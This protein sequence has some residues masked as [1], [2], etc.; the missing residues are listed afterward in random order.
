[1]KRFFSFLI[2]FC[3]TLSGL[4][5]LAAPQYDAK[6]VLLMDSA[7]GAVLYE[8]NAHEPLPPASVTKV[9]TML[10]LMEAIDR[11]EVGYDTVVTASERARSMGGST[12][13]LDTGEQMTIDDLLKGIAVASGNDACVAVAEHLCGS[14]EAFV[15]RMNLRASELGMTNTHFVN[16]N[17]L[18]ADGHVSSAMDIAIMSRELMKHTDIFKYTT[19]WMDSLRDG[20][21]QLANTN[22]LIRFYDGATGLKTG[23]TNNAL[24]CLSATAKRDGLHLIAVVMGS[25]TSQARFNAARSLLD[26][27]FASFAAVTL[28][29]E[30]EIVRSEKVSKG[31]KPEVGLAPAESTSALLPKEQISKVETEVSVSPLSAPIEKGQ[32]IGEMRAL[33]DGEE[34]A[35]CDLLAADDVPRR[36]VFSYFRTL[37]QEYMVL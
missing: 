8:D 33:L 4:T 2:F 17:G 13:F 6:S 7:S 22:K 19:I 24:C 30:G 28:G 37:L 25:P 26:Y 23:S 21:F 3:I 9:M 36:G 18:D 16:C 12:I 5:S 27:G 11:G 15:D 14:V 20:A 35:R 34:I 29:T 10:L 32:V 1:M 31:T